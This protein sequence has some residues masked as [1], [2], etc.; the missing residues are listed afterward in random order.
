M[1]YQRKVQI[2]NRLGLHARA[3]T[4]LVELAQSFDAQ[5][6]VSNADKNASADSIMGLMLLESAQ[7]MEVNIHSSGPQAL[8]ALDAI[9]QLVESRFDE[10]E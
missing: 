2:I 6:T 8:E 4:K 9:Q 1:E 10:N 5:V 7:G 3:A